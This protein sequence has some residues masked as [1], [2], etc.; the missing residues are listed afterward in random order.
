MAIYPK[1]IWK[2]PIPSSNYQASVSK[3]IG[4][5]VHVI[6]GSANSAISE[7]STPGEELS[8]HFVVS[9]AGDPHP[10]GTIFQ[11]ID[12]DYNAYAQEA[13]NYPP[14]AY[15]AVEFS[16]VPANPMTTGQVLSGA[17]IFAWASQLY[18]FPLYGPVAHGAPGITS[19]CNPDG[20]PDPAWGDHTC[21]G[22]GP[23]L[24]QI[25]QI[26]YLAAISLNPTPSPVPKVESN[27]ATD[28]PTGGT[29]VVRPSGAVY[30]YGGSRY[31]GSPLQ[32][33]PKLPPGGSNSFVPDAPIVGIASTKTGL[34]YWMVGSDGGLFAFGDAVYHGS[35]A[36]NPSWIRPVVGIALDPTQANG[37]VIVSD[38]GGPI[39]ATYV[40]NQTTHYS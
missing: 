1:A 11:L 2:G 26:V 24:A 7:F 34:G 39:P 23:R 33:N 21:P 32:V 37:Y 36:A 13:G 9:G 35:V 29:L 20:T 16:G 5:V 22:P 30:N 4:G 31:W 17:A 19:H 18:G 15:I 28:V 6:V 3:K 8:A 14:T 12:T 40:C 25:P 27:M 38:N 10:D